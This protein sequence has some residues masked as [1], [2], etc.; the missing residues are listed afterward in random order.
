MKRVCLLGA[1]GSIGRQ[2]LDVMKKNPSDFSLVSFSVGKQTRKISSILR[3]FPSVMAVCIGDKSKLSYYKKKYPNITFFSGDDGLLKLIDIPANMV[4]NALVGFVGL[5]PTLHALEKNRIVCL[6]NKEALVVGGELVNDLL[7]K[8]F[9]KL[10]PIDSEHSAL[11]KCL[12]VDDKNVSKL[13]LTAS[14]GAFRNLNREQL[15]NV[16]P[17][18]A[19]KHPTWR[20][21]NKITIDCATMINKAFEVI[22]AH[23]LF[24]YPYEQIGIKL[25]DESMVHSY[26]I[27]NDGSL[28]LDIGK[29]DM[30]KP[31][32][33]ALYEF[34]TSFETK[35]ADS[36]EKFSKWHFH[37]FDSKR[38]PI[39]SLAEK[40][41]KEKG[42][43]G[44][45]FNA[46]NEVAV[47]AF[48]NKE[49]PFLMIEDIVSQAMKEHKNIK[50]P[51]YAKIAEI[52]AK[53]RLFA[54]KMI[55]DWRKKTCK[56]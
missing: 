9:G 17:E 41:I 55:E 21:G 49:I 12:M 51:N 44:A 39:V 48:L 42:T 33:L 16:A 20:M 28:R 54:R 4:V 45:V 11:K 37:D 15:K 34:L 56:C 18:D 46:S 14:G 13:V 30:R 5:L 53:T 25:H 29:P 38:Y 1:S 22:E 26:I 50:H 31:I 6:A 52:D 32:K 47:H 3:Q 43:Y 23:Y 2:T 10:Y 24:G 19:L 40:V 35:T 27:Y 7:N 8:G 36:L